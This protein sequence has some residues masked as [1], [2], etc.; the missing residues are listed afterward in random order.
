[1]AIL[2]EFIIDA[3]MVPRFLL[4]NHKFKFNIEQS[5]RILNETKIVNIFNC[6]LLAEIV[7]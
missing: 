7:N 2:K 4:I 6:S 1:M 5:G 3:S